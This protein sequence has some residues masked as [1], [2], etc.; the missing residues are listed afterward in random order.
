MEH[1]AA[2]SWFP[3]TQL[4]NLICARK[5]L[6]I[7]SGLQMLEFPFRFLFSCQL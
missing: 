6:K 5:H 2:M 4:Q 1:I 7:G 3:L